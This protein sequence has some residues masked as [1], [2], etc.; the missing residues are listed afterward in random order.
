[1]SIK[2]CFICGRVTPD[3]Q[4][5]YDFMEL[6]DVTTFTTKTPEIR[7]AARHYCPS[8]AE[9]LYK[10]KAEEDA[11]YSRI[12]GNR[13]MRD[14]LYTLEA[15]GIDLYQ[16][17]NTI[18]CIKKYFATEEGAAKMRE[19][20]SSIELALI[21]LLAHRGIRFLV[22]YTVDTAPD[23]KGK[24]GVYRVDIAVPLANRFIEIDGG[25][26]HGEGVHADPG[27]SDRDRAI[28]ALHPG[29]RFIRVPEDQIKTAALKTVEDII[30]ELRIGASEH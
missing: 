7:A 10:N 1:M 19:I 23:I 18:S 26:Y 3:N 15:Q 8:C 22:Q 21:I 13:K 24:K 16:Y 5:M 14:A 12:R 2:G 9:K 11:T 30:K 6:W 20:G 17:Q 27:E 25:R 28:L 4:S 29:F